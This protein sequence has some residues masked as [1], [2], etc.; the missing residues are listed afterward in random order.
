MIKYICDTCGKEVKKEGDLKSYW[1]TSKDNIEL[2]CGKEINKGSGL[3]Y[4]CEECQ[5]K[6]SKFIISI[7]K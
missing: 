4:V 7:V 6:I 2:S 5:E 3:A 1:I